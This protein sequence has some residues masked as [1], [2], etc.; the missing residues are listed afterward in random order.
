MQDNSDQFATPEEESAFHEEVVGTDD[1]VEETEDH[2][3]ENESDGD[4][5][6]EESE[7]VKP[8]KDGYV[9]ITD[10]K[11][12]ARVDQLSREKHEAI[13][14]AQA[15][16]RRADTLARELE[17][18]RRPAPPKEVPPPNADPITD[19][20]LFARQQQER[21][22]YIREQTKY[23]S[24]AEARTQAKQ[25]AEVQK[26]SEMVNG[27][28]ANMERLKLNPQVL[29]KA[30]ETCAK[31]GVDDNHPLV[32][33]LLED[34]DGPAIV[35]YLADNPEHLSEIANLKPTKALAYIEREIRAKLNVKP[36]SKAPPPPTKVNGTRQSG[37]SNDGWEL[38]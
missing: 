8:K 21:D 26:R 5:E 24:D 9:E 19:P 36:Q 6:S 16:A 38:S 22:K 11:V 37:R 18:L 31:Y 1:P 17:E 15:D 34:S 33:D 14:K 7:K 25:Q 27:Y 2:S 32:E 3:E 4:D 10:P 13:R 35:K 29:A 30:A 12:K 23:D 28:L 20:E